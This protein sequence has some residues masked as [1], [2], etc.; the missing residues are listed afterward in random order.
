MKQSSWQANRLSY[1]HEIVCS[2]RNPRFTFLFKT[3]SVLTCYHNCMEQRPSWEDNSFSA[4]QEISKFL[5]KPTVHCCVYKN[6]QLLPVRNLA[7]NVPRIV[8]NEFCLSFL[9]NSLPSNYIFKLQTMLYHSMERPAVLLYLND[10]C[11]YLY[12]KELS[13]YRPGQAQRVPGGWGSQI[14]RQSA[15]EGDKVVSPTHRPPLPP[16]KYSWY[17]FLLEAESTAGP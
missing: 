5:W 15:H 3:E 4:G 13:H 10:H 17:S 8:I 11:S 6:P 2:L 12:K 16:R 7:D 9:T 14:S 1:S